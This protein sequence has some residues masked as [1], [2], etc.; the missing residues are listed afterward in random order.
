MIVV[1]TNIIAYLWIPG[2][3]TEEVIKETENIYETITETIEI[4]KRDNIPTSEAA[5]KLAKERLDVVGDKKQ[6][7][8][9]KGKI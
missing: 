2:T 4:S 5:I 9:G 6:I 7:Y 8:I 3:Y 1:D